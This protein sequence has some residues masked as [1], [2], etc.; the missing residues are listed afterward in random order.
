MWQM[1]P[2]LYHS[3]CLFCLCMAGTSAVEWHYSVT[4]LSSAGYVIKNR[5]H[6]LW[7]LSRSI[8]LSRCQTEPEARLPLIVERMGKWTSVSL[9]ILV[10]SVTTFSYHF[11]IECLWGRWQTADHQLPLV[12]NKC[13]KRFM[14]WQTEVVGSEK[15]NIYILYILQQS[16]FC[17]GL[18]WQSNMDQV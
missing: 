18:N 11:F 13:F 6:V 12:A 15:A 2:A 10:P 9:H 8:M 17:Q 16:Y 4:D 5:L 3:V 7:R 14:K 1:I